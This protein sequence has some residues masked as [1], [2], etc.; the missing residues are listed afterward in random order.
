MRMDDP[1]PIMVKAFIEAR[2]DWH[3]DVAAGKGTLAP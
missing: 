2:V 1:D 3:C